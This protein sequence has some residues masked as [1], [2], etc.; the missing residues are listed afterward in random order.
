MDFAK[1]FS[2][3]VLAWMPTMVTPMGH[4]ALPIAICRYVSL[5]YWKEKGW[6]SLK[7]EAREGEDIQGNL[8]ELPLI[9]N[10]TLSAVPI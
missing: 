1:I 4:G 10:G 9:N 3:P 2:R 6:K 8:T 5:A 7:T